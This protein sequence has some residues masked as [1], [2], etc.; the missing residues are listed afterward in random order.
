MS[1]AE[2]T[3]NFLLQALLA[4]ALIMA[5]MPML[6]QKLSD[7]KNDMNMSASA[8]H[9]VAAATAGREFVR[10]SLDDIPYGLQTFTDG[11]FSDLLEP[12]G[13]PLGFVPI[14]P[15]NQKISFITAKKDDDFMAALVLNGGK[16][17]KTLKAEL[18]MRI[19]PDAAAADDKGILRGIGGW[20]VNLKDFGI[21]PDMDAIYVLVPKDDDFSELVRRDSKDKVRNRFHTNLDMGGFSV[22]NAN[23][24]LS[25]NT[26]LDIANFGTLSINGSGGDR[27]FK[28]NI[29]LISANRAVFQTRDGA[30]A[31][32]ITRGD[33]V[34]N[35]VSAQTLF[36]YG[37]PGAIEADTVSVNSLA[38]SAGR[39]GFVG[40]YDWDVRGDMV[41][42]NVSLNTEILE[43][44]GFIN[45]SR[46][47]DVFIDESELTYSS[48][49]GI[50]VGAIQSAHITLRDQISSA[51][52]TEGDGAT[53]LDI[54]PAG[55][56]VLPDV[57]L[58]T[59]NNDDF[60]ILKNP[61]EDDS[62][63]VS[64]K[65]IIDGLFN[66]P[67]YH[68]NS[69]AQNIVCQYV[70]WHRLERRIN[71]KQCKLDGEC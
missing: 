4:I 6:A 41:L 12:F 60:K 31:L 2:E 47:Q 8:R 27:K 23:S 10:A 18:M 46:G 57:L 69:V 43:I 1:R 44:G 13:L 34:A 35:S 49:H 45:A 5:F 70:F 55:V 21:K 3:G 40:P 51:L 39:T 32:N 7:R 36:K 24:I 29:E 54:R 62:A 22:V 11:D 28:N 59:I 66:A 16:M 67:D 25:S 19:G 64:C 53:I 37:M 61:E 17:S 52:L 38:L 63:T 56:S 9:I 26:R 30:N 15:Q 33:L 14:T 58:E 68:R 42:S 65:N 50:E 48:R 71:L 20:D